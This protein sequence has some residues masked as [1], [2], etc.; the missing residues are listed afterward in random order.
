MGF[1]YSRFIEQEILDDQTHER[2]APSL[3]DIVRINRLLGGHEVLRKALRGIVSRA[4]SFKLLD[5]GAGSGDAGG[6]VLRE[7][8]RASV[9]SLDYRLHHVREAR[10]H[11]IVADAFHLPL[12]HNS[13]DIVY[14]GLFLHHFTDDDTVQLL[15]N[16]AA[17]SRRY[18]IVNDLERNILPYYFLPATRWLLQWDPITIHDGMI[19]VQAAFTEQEMRSLAGRA[20]LRNIRVRTHRPS[21]RV[22]MVAEVADDKLR[23]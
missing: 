20:G 19:S 5:V 7:Y 8:P 18:V 12:R 9:F 2:A 22:S 3:A 16:M 11:R 17:V 13:F 1:R 23:V 21:F 10:T 15:H 6:V 4:A 14:A